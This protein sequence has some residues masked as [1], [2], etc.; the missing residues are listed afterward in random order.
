MMGGEGASYHHN[1]LVHHDSRCPRL[2][3][4][5]ATGARDTTD[6]RCNVMYNWSGQGCY[7]AENMNANI[8]NNYY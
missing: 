2:G 5:P 8:V 6:F 3:E 7:G 1:L 4:R